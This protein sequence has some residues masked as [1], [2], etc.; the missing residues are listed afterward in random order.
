VDGTSIPF[1]SAEQ[2]VYDKKFEADIVDVK[3]SNGSTR[4]ELKLFLFVQNEKNKP[5]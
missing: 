4:K 5:E 3:L 1:R 2:N